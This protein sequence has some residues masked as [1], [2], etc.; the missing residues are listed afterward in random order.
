MIELFV[1][2]FHSK[3]FCIDNGTEAIFLLPLLFLV[4]AENFICH[5]LFFALNQNTAACVVV[6]AWSRMI[7]TQI[8]S[9]GRQIEKFRNTDS[10]VTCVP[11]ELHCICIFIHLKFSQSKC[12]CFEEIRRHTHTQTHVYTNK[13]SKNFVD[14]RFG[15]RR[16]CCRCYC[17]CCCFNKSSVLLE[18]LLKCAVRAKLNSSLHFIFLSFLY[19]L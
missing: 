4:S 9:S 7:K 10:S 8:I 3:S 13:S 14:F 5:L 18:M 17:C 6:V 15:C 19:H 1:F 12:V 2:V 11:V 16:R